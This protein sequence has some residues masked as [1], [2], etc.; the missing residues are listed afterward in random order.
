MTAHPDPKTLPPEIVPW[1]TA[2]DDATRQLEIAFDAW[3]AAPD[4][5]TPP[6]F[7]RADPW[8]R[9]VAQ[10]T[11]TGVWDGEDSPFFP[12]TLALYAFL[13]EHPEGTDA[14]GDA[15]YRQALEWKKT[16]RRWPFSMLAGTLEEWGYPASCVQAVGALREEPDD[17]SSTRPKRLDPQVDPAERF[18]RIL[19]QPSATVHRLMD[20]MR[21][22]QAALPSRQS[23]ARRAHLMNEMPRTFVRRLD[24]YVADLFNYRTAPPPETESIPF[25]LTTYAFLAAH[26]VYSE[27][28]V[29]TALAVALALAERH[30]TLSLEMFLL[31]LTRDGYPETALRAID[32]LVMGRSTTP[33]DE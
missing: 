12:Y 4:N 14:D 18:A 15:A 5:P 32:D 23:P 25:N 6:P 2:L 30:G 7:A 31:A 11:V 20:G 13:L 10:L 3:N 29:R 28:N 24:T 27:D 8:R 26:P 33:S 16:Y 22:L 17:P 1:I 21:C 9:G 19:P